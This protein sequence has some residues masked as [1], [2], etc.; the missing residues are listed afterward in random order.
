MK[1]LTDQNKWNAACDIM[2]ETLHNAEL[3]HRAEIR[4]EGCCHEL[5]TI[6]SSLLKKLGDLRL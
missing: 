5:E 2:F 6:R 3:A 4:G 1:G